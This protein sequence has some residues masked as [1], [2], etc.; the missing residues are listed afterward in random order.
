MLEQFSVMRCGHE[1]FIVCLLFAVCCVRKVGQC[2][3]VIEK[4]KRELGKE[5]KCFI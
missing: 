4:V 3:E 1:G 2:F 5:R